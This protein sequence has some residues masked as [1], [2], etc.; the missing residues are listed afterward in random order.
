MNSIQNLQSGDERAYDAMAQAAQKSVSELL[1]PFK[2]APDAEGLL[3][4]MS[5]EEFFRRFIVYADKFTDGCCQDYAKIMRQCAVVPEVRGTPTTTLA[6]QVRAEVFDTLDS[7]LADYIRALRQLEIDLTNVSS[8]LRGSSMV[9]AAM[10]GAAIG[11]LAG[12]LGSSGQTLGAINALLQ[13]GVEAE[14]QLAL[15]QQRLELLKQAQSMTFPKIVEYLKAVSVLPERLLDYGCAKCFGGQISFDHQRRALEAIS[16]VVAQ[17]MESAINLTL[18]LSDA[19]K[20]HEQ[21]R[22][23][24]AKEQQERETNKPRPGRG[25]LLVAASIGMVMW[26]LQS[27]GIVGDNKVITE[28]GMIWGL[29]LMLGAPFVLLLGVVK[30]IGG[31]PKANDPG[32]KPD[33][34]QSKPPK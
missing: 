9:D 8:E 20:R 30:F 2:A 22:L 28:G 29:I 6:K 16:T 27:C 18:A 23:E 25:V 1:I 12:G 13:A 5:I 34:T 24:A 32:T 7:I 10:K 21:E 31:S 11:Q 17:E 26:S 14:K 15:L 3:R 33:G 4:A 19:E